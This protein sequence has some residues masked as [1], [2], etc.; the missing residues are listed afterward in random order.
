MLISSAMVN[1]HRARDCLLR[2]TLFDGRQAT[3]EPSVGA[4]ALTV[5]GCPAIEGLALDNT[6]LP[7]TRLLR[8]RL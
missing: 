6:V 2:Q 7:A 3:L 8:V 5:R 4:L 1:I